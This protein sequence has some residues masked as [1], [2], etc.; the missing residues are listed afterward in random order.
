MIQYNDILAKLR[1][2]CTSSGHMKWLQFW[3]NQHKHFVPAFRGFFLPF[4]NI[5]ESGQSCMWAQ[6]LHGKM[7]SLVDALYKDIPKQMHMDAMYKAADRQEVVDTGKYLNLLDLQLYARNEQEQ[8]APMLARNLEQGNQWLEDSTLEN[9]EVD[10]DDNFYPPETA[11]HKFVESDD[12]TSTEEISLKRTSPA[13]LTIPD[14]KKQKSTTSTTSC[15][16]PNESAS[17]MSNV[18]GRGRGVR[19]GR[20]RETVVDPG[21]PIGGGVHPLGGHGPLTWVLFGEN[22]C[23]NERIGVP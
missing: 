3:H 1:M 15:N 5:A 22:V 6:Q 14:A 10:K 23:K 13:S 4:M 8:C 9:P 17:V 16:I 19:G 21:F 11:A 7:L 20:G 18:K 12:E 2:M